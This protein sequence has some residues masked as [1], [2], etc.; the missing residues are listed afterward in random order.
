[1]K[2]H[3]YHPSGNDRRNKT[4]LL[5]PSWGCAMKYL[6]P[7]PRIV[8]PLALW[9]FLLTFGGLAIAE[10]DWCDRG[11]G[12]PAGTNLALDFSAAHAG[13]RFFGVQA[14]YSIADQALATAVNPPTAL[15]TGGLG[16][17]QSYSQSLGGVCVAP[18]NPATLGPV[19]VFRLGELMLI[20][21][22]T[23]SVQ[24]PSD[25]SLVAIDLR[26][27]PELPGLRAALEATV[28]LALKNPVTRPTR[29]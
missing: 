27:L 12:G 24:I 3:A 23:G 8:F 26:D 28:A 7:F 15:S 21:P 19:Q 14:K 4:L 10:D 6:R 16:T 2:Y 17:L 25:V 29:T 11:G 13:A 9:T 5:F 18:D 1:M 22:G 20:R